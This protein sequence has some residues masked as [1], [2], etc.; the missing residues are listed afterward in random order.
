MMANRAET[1]ARCTAAAGLKLTGG[2]L[3]VAVSLTLTSQPAH[4]TFTF[5]NRTSY[6]LASAIARDNGARTDS[7]GWFVL[8]P[9]QCQPVLDEPLHNGVYYTLAYTLP[10]HSGGVKHFAGKKTL[11][12]GQGLG[13]FKI[14]GQEDCERRGYVA[15]KFSTIEIGDN[16]DWT[17]TFTEPTEYTLKEARVAGVQRLLSDVGLD[18]GAIDGYLGARTRSALVN[19]KE[20]HG[21]TPD[22]TLPNGLYD[23][24]VNAAQEAH[25]DV[26]YSFCNDTRNIVWAAIGYESQGDITATGWFR[27]EPRRCSKVIKTRLSRKVYY[28]FAENENGLGRRFAWGGDRVLCTMD[29]RF[30]IREH[31]DCEKHGY[32]PVGF[33][34]VKV[35]D[36]QGYVQRLSAES[37]S[38]SRDALR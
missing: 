28:T 25:E 15:R 35:G 6:V 26:G 10:V 1:R 22:L 13:H 11:C 17:T 32:V 33:A 8:Q 7:H 24:L 14:V 18:A 21:I 29:N 9:G 34:R 19:F 20:K 38:E 12:T 16:E 23:A 5:C 4:A 3:A 2:V 31:Q 27:V 30:T 36:K 37:A